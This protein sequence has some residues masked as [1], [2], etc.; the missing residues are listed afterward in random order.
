MD[1][2]IKRTAHKSRLAKSLQGG[3]DPDPT[4]YPM[5]INIVV[6]GGWAQLKMTGGFVQGTVTGDFVLPGVPDTSIS[7]SESQGN[8]YTVP[9]YKDK[10]HGTIGI[11]VA[12]EDSIISEKGR[13]TIFFNQEA[14]IAYYIAPADKDPQLEQLPA[15]EA[16]GWSNWP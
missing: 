12:N 6:Q 7:F 3:G 9:E 5:S 15:F 1:H 11:G 10:L 14:T 8:L 4:A 13:I 2:F 16:T